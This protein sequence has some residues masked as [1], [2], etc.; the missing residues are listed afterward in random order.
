MNIIISASSM[1]P[2][3][4]QI[5]E[6]VKH[7]ILSGELAENEML[8]SVRTLSRELKISALTAKKAYDCLEE[9]GLIATVHG[10]GS[11]VRA[12]NR[13]L[14]Q[15]QQRRDLEADLEALLE[16]AKRYGVSGEELRAMLD[17][18]YNGKLIGRWID[19]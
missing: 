9:E 4:E 11:F 3:Y 16:K 17:N 7:Q 19:R 12:P 6:A 13:L 14:L 1:T 8:P 18:T 5:V 2:I 15:E 10:K